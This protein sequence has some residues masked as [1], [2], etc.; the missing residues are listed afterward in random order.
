[1]QCLLGVGT[2][3]LLGV[4]ERVNLPGEVGYERFR[5]AVRAGRLWGGM[6]DVLAAAGDRWAPD[7]S[8]KA[9]ANGKC[10]GAHA[11]DDDDAVAVRDGRPK[12]A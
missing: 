7:G 6:P 9:L 3:A 2:E 11:E 5:R 4:S 8:T 1:M 12:R 10:N